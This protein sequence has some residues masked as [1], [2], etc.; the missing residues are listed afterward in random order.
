MTTGKELPDGSA[1]GHT[2][3]ADVRILTAPV[4]TDVT[5]GE[6]TCTILTQLWRDLDSILEF[7]C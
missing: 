6:F 5:M 3:A 4:E 7:Q 2:P 1:G